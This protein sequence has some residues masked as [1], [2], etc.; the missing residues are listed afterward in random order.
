MVAAFGQA[1]KIITNWRTT[2]YKV[3]I[4][5]GTGSAVIAI[6]DAGQSVGYSHITNEGGITDPML[7]SPS[8][9]AT[10]LQDVGGRAQQRRRHQ[11]RRAESWIVPWGC[12][13]VVAIGEGDGA[14]G[15]G[16]P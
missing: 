3:I 15:R 8:G 13:A 2:M 4:L 9:K 16:R 11:R 10:L 7:W 14:P 1:Q 12:G 5:R 6:N